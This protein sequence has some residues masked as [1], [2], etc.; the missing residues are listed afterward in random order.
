MLLENHCCFIAIHPIYRFRNTTGNVDIIW[1]CIQKLLGTFV[2]LPRRDI[3]WSSWCVPYQSRSNQCRLS[4]QWKVFIHCKSIVPSNQR[5]WKVAAWNQVIIG[6]SPQNSAAICWAIKHTS[7]LSISYLLVKSNPLVFQLELF[8]DLLNVKRQFG[9][10]K[11]KLHFVRHQF[12][13]D[14]Y[15]FHPPKGTIYDNRVIFTFYKILIQFFY[16]S[17]YQHEE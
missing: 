16:N 3:G 4:C 6:T 7:T 11:C 1:D 8:F 5:R 2:I 15:E 17:Y 13:V 9:A 10:H 12:A 14:I